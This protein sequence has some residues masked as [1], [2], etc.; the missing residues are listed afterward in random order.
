MFYTAA[1]YADYGELGVA[2]S[3]SRA[4]NPFLPFSDLLFACHSWPVETGEGFLKFIYLF[5]YFFNRPQWWNNRHT[6][7][8]A[9]VKYSRAVRPRD[10]LFSGRFITGLISSAHQTASCG[11]RSRT[12]MPEA[13]DKAHN[14]YRSAVHTL[15]RSTLTY[16]PSAAIHHNFLSN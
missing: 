12:L 7:V 10:G 16:T 15:N 3:L 8:Y 13:Q 4:E 2:S 6:V 14:Q 11:L 1:Y 9:G 5:V